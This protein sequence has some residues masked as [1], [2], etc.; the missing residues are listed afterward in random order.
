MFLTE[1][2]R[3]WL[4][5][6]ILD[7]PFWCHR[8]DLGDGFYTPGDVDAHKYHELGLPADLT[9][10][11]VL[12]I[13]SYNGLFAFEAERRGVER[14]LATD[15]WESDARDKTL[16][17]GHRRRGFEL[18][19][20]FLDSDVEAQSID[21]LD[22]SPDTV[23]GTFDVV[24]CPGVIYRIRPIVE[25]VENLVSVADER[26]VVTSLRPRAPLPTAGMEFYED[27]ERMNDPTIWWA[28][29]ETTL[30]ILFRSAGYADVEMEQLP[31]VTDDSTPPVE[32]VGV[33]DQ[34]VSLYRDH[35]LT[36]QIGRRLIRNTGRDPPSEAEGS[37]VV[38]VLY[39]TDDAARVMYSSEPETGTVE[40]EQAWVPLDAL[41][42]RRDPSLVESAIELLWT[43]GPT[44]L[45]RRTID[46]LR[47]S[48]GL[49]EYRLTA[50]VE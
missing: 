27:A 2:R 47:G 32:T 35:Q 42:A 12:D 43:E 23:G 24:V 31:D 4:E 37:A 30:A 36:D 19:R 6:Q 49:S 33:T 39:R 18:A 3:T 11:S 15:L 34:P 20:S 16:E 41:E 22:V 40:R 13:G 1:E 48:D 21:L 46:F 50:R 38:Q 5:D 28:P 14:V 8:I 7:H 29:D 45:A 44:T 25:A 10:K 9:G 17:T 26:I